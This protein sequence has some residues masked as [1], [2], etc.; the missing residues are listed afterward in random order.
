MMNYYN[1]ILVFFFSIFIFGNV[2]FAENNQVRHIK[3]NPNSKT[4]GQIDGLSWV[5]EA[6]SILAEVENKNEYD[7][8]VIFEIE[9]LNNRGEKIYSESNENNLGKEGESLEVCCSFDKLPNSVKSYKY[10]FPTPKNEYMEAQIKEKYKHILNNIYT[11]IN[12]VM[13]T[14]S[15][16]YNRAN[17][18]MKNVILPNISSTDDNSVMSQIGVYGFD[19]KERYDKSFLL[20]NGAIVYLNQFDR[21]CGFAPKNDVGIKENAGGEIIVDI[22]GKNGPNLYSNKETFN[23]KFKFLIYIDKILPVENSI[24]Y[25]IINDKSISAHVSPNLL[26]S[27]KEEY[28]NYT[29]NIV[30]QDIYPT[31]LLGVQNDNSKD[32][33]YNVEIKF[34]DDKNNELKSLILSEKIEAGCFYNPRLRLDFSI[35][36]KNASSYSIDVINVHMTNK[37]TTFDTSFF[38]ELE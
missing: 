14:V 21:V 22:N 17:L 16:H 31:I 25:N 1:K 26:L 11:A 3:L 2:V 12:L 30:V 19:L 35:I 6:N 7:N 27:E 38:D 4:E 10:V 33:I 23:D 20:K 37:Q 5:F 9:F 18:I 28:R 32:V 24:E 8:S 36:P 34:Y 29:N 13:D 15:V